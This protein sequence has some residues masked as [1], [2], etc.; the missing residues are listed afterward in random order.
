MAIEQ[1]KTLTIIEKKVFNGIQV[2]FSDS[3]LNN[4]RIQANWVTEWVDQEG[5]V[6]NYIS[7]S[8]PIIIDEQTTALMPSVLAIQ[9]YL[10]AKLETIE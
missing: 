2:F 4:L 7:N 9:A 5:N 10:M 8:S 3:Q 1:Q 6:I